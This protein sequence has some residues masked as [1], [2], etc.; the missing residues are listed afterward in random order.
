MKKQHLL[1][2]LTI[3]IIPIITAFASIVS[4]TELFDVILSKIV[5]PSCIKAFKGWTTVVVY[6]TNAIVLAWCC[7]YRRRKCIEKQ[8]QIICFGQLLRA[9][10]RVTLKTFNGQKEVNIRPNIR[11]YRKWKDSLIL[12]DRPGLYDQ[13][14]NDKLSF[15]ISSDEGAVSQ[16]INTGKV[17]YASGHDCLGRLFNLCEY[18]KSLISGI[19]FLVAVPITNRDGSEIVNVVSFDSPEEIIIDNNRFQEFVEHMTVI[20]FQLYYILCEGSLWK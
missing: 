18:Q 10:L 13:H 1:Y 19:N 16:C 8:N 3:A 15:C 11:M 14:I 7:A 20:A 17:I 9:Q 4:Q 2:I 6:V 5:D 12:V